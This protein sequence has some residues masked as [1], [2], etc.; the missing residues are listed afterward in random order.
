MGA[1]S[2]RK[3]DRRHLFSKRDR[4]GGV[5]RFTKELASNE[6]VVD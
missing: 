3:A 4:R 1:L 5:K 2:A 6:A